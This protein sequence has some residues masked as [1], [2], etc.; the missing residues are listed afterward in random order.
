MQSVASVT[1]C[2]QPYVFNMNMVGSH[3]S[4]KNELFYSKK[5][6]GLNGWSKMDVQL[7]DSGDVAH[8]PY[9]EQFSYYARCLEQG[10]TPHNSLESAFEPHAAIFAPGGG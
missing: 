2:M 9:R 3:G 7:V 10:I 1:D 8:H 5:I 4:L 6:A